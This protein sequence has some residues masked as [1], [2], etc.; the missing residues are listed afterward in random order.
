MST[1]TQK[2]LNTKPERKMLSQAHYYH[3]HVKNFMNMQ[4]LEGYCASV[5]HTL[6][7]N[8]NINTNNKVNTTKKNYISQN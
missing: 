3:Y 8:T 7:T 4:F 1:H 5:I 6:I 2:L